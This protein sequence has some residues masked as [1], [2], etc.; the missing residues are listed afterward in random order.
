[1]PASDRVAQLYPQ[2]PGSPFVTYYDLQGYDG[3]TLTRL[4][5][6]LQQRIPAINKFDTTEQKQQQKS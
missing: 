2:A 1:M 5:T 4:H 3:G 6:G